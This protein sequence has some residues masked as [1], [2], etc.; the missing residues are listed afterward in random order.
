MKPKMYFIRLVLVIMPIFVYSCQNDSL[1]SRS[2]TKS[3]EN[4]FTR[5]DDNKELKEEFSKALAK[6][7]AESKEVRELIKQEALKKFDHDY[8]V[9]YQL[10]KNQKLLNDTTFEGLL[11]KYINEETL[12]QIQEKLPTLT[13]LVPE[14]PEKSFS[15]EAWNTGN[16]I[17]YVAIRLNNRSDVP[18]YD[19]TGEVFTLKGN[20]VPLF[21]VVVVK[22][23][24][25][26]VANNANTNSTTQLRSSSNDSPQFTVTDSI[27]DN[28]NKSANVLR[29]APYET[30]ITS[31]DPRTG[32][33]IVTTFPVPENRRKILDAYDIYKNVVN[34]WQRDY[35]YYNL[36]P[37]NTVGPFHNTFME[38][39]VG[40]EMVGDANGAFNKISDQTGDPKR[41]NS[42]DGRESFWTDGEF[43]FQVKV[44]VG[45]KSAFGN[46][47]IK[48]FR[49]KP[50]DLFGL[51]MQVD[52]GNTIGT[53][54]G[55]TN[56]KIRL[57]LPLFDWNIENYSANIKI[58]IEEVDNPQT[59]ISTTSTTAEFASNF[60]F[61]PSWGTTVKNGLQFGA[62]AKETRTV[63]Y[64]VTTTNGNDVLGEV[65]VNFSDP[66]IISRTITP[67][68]ESD[69]RSLTYTEGLLDYNTKYS[70]GWYR[71][72][73]APLG[74]DP[75]VSAPVSG[76]VDDVIIS[77]PPLPKPGSNLQILTPAL[78]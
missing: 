3:V 65:I 11:S 63:S 47:L 34:G 38:Y 64:Q 54:I 13:I 10:V 45:N 39:L 15:A 72:Y 67:Y 70:T 6:V 30:T 23:N 57:E 37:T 1:T 52:R 74:I 20:E 19:S 22:E 40:F 44:Y 78:Q 16:E 60:S 28:T 25:R 48:N 33:P 32:N 43:E 77:K 41:S 76:G 66:I 4:S 27:F 71:L 26:V 50:V 68:S 69:G 61:S 36:T 56:K 2:E 62:S 35:I 14:L 51:V 42:T 58:G 7:L 53:V 24:E 12:A 8:D 5:K 46:E 59:T 31:Y 49:A 9:L 29:S 55:M 73:I 17:P 21:P 75:P 18:V